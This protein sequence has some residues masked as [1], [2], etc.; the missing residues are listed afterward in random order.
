MSDHGFRPVDRVA[1]LDDVLVELGFANRLSSSGR[2]HLMARGAAR[3]AR[4]A[5]RI[6][7][8]RSGLDT[9]FSNTLRQQLLPQRAIDWSRTAAYQSVRGGGLSINAKGR[10][11][12]GIVETGEPF[13][14]VRDEV[15]QAL[16]DY[17]DPRTGLQPVEDVLVSEQLY[18]GPQVDLAPDLLVQPSA[19][20]SFPYTETPSGASD[21]PSGAH[22]RQGIIV[23]AG[24]RTVP[25]G[26]GE[27]DIADVAAT[28]L[29]F[30][31]VTAPVDGVPIMEIAGG[32][33][34]PDVDSGTDVQM[35]RAPADLTDAEQAQ[36]AEHLR[37][38]GYIE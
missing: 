34:P 15:R 1:N 3:A 30:C 8:L 7:F 23:A 4:V 16:L 10:E 21:W 13:R 38:L 28:A 37:N 17:R 14:R 19:L 2:R 27:R 24:G 9:R 22:R 32:Q 31:G 20:W 29:A 11:R 18:S 33:E 26:L 5:R 6:P 35:D 25:G 12:H 36:M